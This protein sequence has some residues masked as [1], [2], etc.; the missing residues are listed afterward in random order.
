MIVADSCLPK[1]YAF[2]SYKKQL[3]AKA[4]LISLLRKLTAPVAK[5]AKHW[6]AD[7]AVPGSYPAEGGILVSVN[8]VPLHTAVHYHPPFVIYNQNTMGKGVNRKSSV[9]SV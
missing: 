9:H 8:G 5:N 2:I 4:R 6:P 1:G 7:L 3:Y